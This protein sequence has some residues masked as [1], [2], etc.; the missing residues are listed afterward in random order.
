LAVLF[1]GD[2]YLAE[3]D[4]EANEFVGGVEVETDF[5]VGGG[6]FESFVGSSTGGGCS[7]G[8]D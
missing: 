6:G 3:G 2:G 7:R 4:F 1:A 8:F 5:E